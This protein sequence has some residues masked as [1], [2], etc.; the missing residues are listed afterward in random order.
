ME[1]C[2]F[3]CV[4]VIGGSDRGFVVFVIGLLD[5]GFDISEVDLISLRKMLCVFL[6]LM[7]EGIFIIFGFCMIDEDE[8]LL[9]LKGVC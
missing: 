5:F 1:D 9:N 8:V 6:E 4:F 2:F 7:V 3:G